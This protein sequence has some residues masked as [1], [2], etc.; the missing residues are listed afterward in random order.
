LNRDSAIAALAGGYDANGD[1]TNDGSRQFAYDRE[2]RLAGGTISATSVS[3][4][5]AYDPAA[6]LRQ[7]QTTIGANPTVTTQYLY[8]G[9]QLS[10]EYDASG[11]LLR[12][13]VHASGVDEP[14]VWYEGSGVA[15]RR[16]LHVDERGSIVAWSSLS[17]AVT[18]VGYGPYGEPSTWGGSRFAYTGQIQLA[19]VQ[20]YHYK[21]RA[22]DPAAGR[23]M[24]IDPIGY[25]GGPNLYEYVSGDPLNLSDPTGKIAFL[26]QNPQYGNL[27]G[28]FTVPSSAGS[29]QYA[30][31]GYNT[32]MAFGA[33]SAT[34]GVV[35]AG[36]A[37]N[38]KAVGTGMVALPVAGVALGAAVATIP[39][40][41]TSSTVPSVT[42][43]TAGTFSASETTALRGL[44]GNSTSGV[45]AL[46]QSIESGAFRPPPGITTQLLQRYGAVAERAIL[47]GKDK[48]GVQVLRLEA[49]KLLTGN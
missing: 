30:A 48:I 16:W 19:E 37:A 20:L 29:F 38:S 1:L 5:L 3:V 31:N 15:D 2:N 13:Y 24:Q 7:Q 9:S 12:R 41:A 22:Y 14:I 11:A 42:N 8:A 17:G 4:V 6:R 21:A 33:G 49:I 47:A 35:A 25:E 43:L 26:G 45:K 32:C 46:I 28:G 40:A 36:N 10:A 23:F 39:A 18:V 27:T 34:C 44:F